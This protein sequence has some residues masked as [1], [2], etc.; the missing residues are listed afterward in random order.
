MS[1]LFLSEFMLDVS[2]KVHR[3]FFVYVSLLN[4]AG[5]LGLM[6][7]FAFVGLLPLLSFGMFAEYEVKSGEWVFIRTE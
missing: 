7:Q 2:I 5:M 3:L 6:Y 1:F 4:C